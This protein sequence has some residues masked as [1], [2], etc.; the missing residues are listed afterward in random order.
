MLFRQIGRTMLISAAT[1]AVAVLIFLVLTTSTVVT[2]AERIPDSELAK[3]Y[4]GWWFYN[5]YC[6]FAGADD[7]P[8]NTSCQTY[9]RCRFCVPVLGTLC[10]YGSS[11]IP[12]WDGCINGSSQC[13]NRPWAP[14]PDIPNMYGYCSMGICLA[15]YYDP[16]Q[17]YPECNQ[18]RYDWCDD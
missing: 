16:E 2:A 11:A 12:D 15:E 1:M 4:G 5:P 3:L 6:V 13:R 17:S 18:Y 7:C 9:A 8:A 14:V 10:H